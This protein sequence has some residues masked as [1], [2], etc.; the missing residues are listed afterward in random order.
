VEE[1]KTH[2]GAELL[3][4]LC[5][6]GFDLRR[7][8]SEISEM[9]G[10]GAINGALGDLKDLLLART[11]SQADLLQMER[12]LEILDVNFPRHEPALLGELEIMG[13]V[14]LED[15]L[16]SHLGPDSPAPLN[17]LSWR[18]GFMPRLMEAAAFH[19]T[20][21]W[22]R[23]IKDM[24]L[25]PWAEERGAEKEILAEREKF[26]NSVTLCFYF[27]HSYHRVRREKMALLR[28]LRTAVHYRL[29]GEIVIL[30]D[31]FGSKLLHR[32]SESK[33]KIWSVGIDGVDDGGT[34]GWEASNK[35][36]VLQVER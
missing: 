20:D 5:Q 32:E 23:R 29:T 18:Y 24:D 30:D 19:E 11:L 16:I 27:I 25:R 17:L 2:E 31:P 8:T 9:C 26:S 33:L 15:R 3:L 36:I 28:L 7:D 34:G 1:G 10:D 6:F 22:V 14:L 12:E 21:G 13:E 4:D 35:D